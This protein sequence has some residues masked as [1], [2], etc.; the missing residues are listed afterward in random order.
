MIKGILI[1]YGGTIDTNGRHWAN[2]I[3]EA[4]VKAGVKVEKE[5]FMQAYAYGEKSL[6]IHPII[7]P[8][9]T[10]N[11]VLE[12][13]LK[14]QFEFLDINAEDK[15]KVITATCMDVVQKTVRQ[16]ENTLT[17]LAAEYPLVLV[18][19]FYGNIQ[20]VLRDLQLDHFFKAIV[21]SAVVGIRKPDAGIYK[22]G[23]ERIGLKAEECVVIGDSYKKDILP[24]KEAG[25]KT[26]W[27]NVDGFA[28]DLENAVS[29]VAD[30]QIT[31]FAQIPASIA[32]LT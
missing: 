25:C 27:I 26:I 12:L 19:N 5:R 7:K 17:L 9:H 14:Q 6:A 20:A 30:L 13:K 4:Y 24:G 22:L 28:E 32:K 8:S 16:A 18:S 29:G 31:D 11:D 2:V 15:I 21:E 1:D 23:V 10:F 3:W